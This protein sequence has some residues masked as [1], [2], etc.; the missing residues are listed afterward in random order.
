MRIAIR[1]QL[2]F[3]LFTVG[4]PLKAELLAESRWSDWVDVGTPPGVK[5]LFQVEVNQNKDGK[6]EVF[7]LGDDNKLW[8][9]SRSLEYHYNCT[10][11][12]PV[13][14][15]FLEKLKQT[16]CSSVHI[17]SRPLELQPKICQGHNEPLCDKP[18]CYTDK[19]SLVT[20]EKWVWNPLGGATAVIPF[21]RFT[22]GQH[23]DGRLEVF[24]VST[25]Y[26][27]WHIW[28]ISSSGDWGGWKVLDSPGSEH[29]PTD[30]R[31][32]Q[33]EDGRLIILLS[34][35]GLG[36]EHKLWYRWQISSI[37]D[38]WGM[39]KSFTMPQGLQ[40]YQISISSVTQNKNGQLEIFAIG[41]TGF[42]HDFYDAIWHKWQTSPNDNDWS[43][44]YKFDGW[45]PYQYL[46]PVS[47]ITI[48]KNEDGRLELF[49][50]T[51]NSQPNHDKPWE[52]FQLW[53]IWQTSPNN[54]W[55]RWTQ[56]VKSG[57]P[58]N[59]SWH[60]YNP[61]FSH[62]NYDLIRNKNKE[63]EFFSLGADNNLWHVWQKSPNA[64]DWSDWH[65]L[66]KP[67]DS[68]VHAFVIRQNKDGRLLIV[69]LCNEGNTESWNSA[70]I[71]MKEESLGSN[72]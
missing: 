42:H 27:L 64:N 25:D 21:D 37:S 24:A 7:A 33:S 14:Q 13:S 3:I 16:L 71:W 5:V 54:G 44:W 2:L 53:H 28:Q 9:A 30:I 38:E 31:S 47:P 57:Q 55:D 23:N 50:S 35:V 8:H 69:A 68:Y 26:K 59:I 11:K 46:Y 43:E 36:S 62:A 66:E 63:L 58:E 39:W 12:V 20:E 40:H 67:R 48:S 22:I 4:I 56:L 32:A 70:D 49:A 1:K 51:W 19:C 60:D 34:T 18:I 72:E 41:G 65:H 17:Q 29:Y 52:E 61:P 10:T 6:W 45:P 15:E